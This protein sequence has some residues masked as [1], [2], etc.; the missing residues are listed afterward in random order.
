MPEAYRAVTV[1]APVFQQITQALRDGLISG[2]GARD[3]AGVF[4]LSRLKRERDGPD[5]IAWE[6][7]AMHAENA[8]VAAGLTKGLVTGLMGALGE[9][10]E[11]SGHPE[12]GVMAY[13]TSFGST[14]ERLNNRQINRPR[15]SVP[16]VS[17][18]ALPLISDSSVA[19]LDR[20]SLIRLQKGEGPCFRSSTCC[21]KW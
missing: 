21:P 13:T 15:R 17:P 10:Q 7:W 1:E 16:A 9:L 5:E 19:C 12:T 4:P 11:H 8:A 2:A 6:Q 18:Y 20:S 3:R 14:R